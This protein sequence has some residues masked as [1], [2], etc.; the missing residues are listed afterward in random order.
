MGEPANDLLVELR[1][2]ADAL[3]RIATT[4]SGK[5]PTRRAKQRKVAPP[6]PSGGPVDEIA[7]ARADAAL[8][9]AGLR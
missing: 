1:R 9:R 8:K 2:I 5:L 3:E 6:A 7:R 4:P